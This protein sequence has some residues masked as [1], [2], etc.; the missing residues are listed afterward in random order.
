MRFPPIPGFSWSNPQL[1]KSPVEVTALLWDVRIAG[2]SWSQKGDQDNC[3]SWARLH[4]ANWQ[5]WSHISSREC[6]FKNTRVRKCTQPVQ[7]IQNPTQLEIEIVPRW[8]FT[9]TKAANT[10]GDQPSLVN[11][12][13][14]PDVCPIP[15]GQP[16]CTASLRVWPSKNR[17]SWL[18]LS[19]RF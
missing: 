7:A 14:G 19:P 4:M 17:D 8:E 3:D 18:L 12:H 15:R 16:P 10:S 1:L 9:H 13:C 5:E 6:T 11:N 2:H